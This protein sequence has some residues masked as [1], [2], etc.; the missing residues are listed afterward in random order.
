MPPK[1]RTVSRVC[2]TFENLQILDVTVCRAIKVSNIA[3]LCIDAMGRLK[4]VTAVPVTPTASSTAPSAA[5]RGARGDGLNADV[6]TSSRFDFKE[7][8]LVTKTSGAK[9]ILVIS[10]VVGIVAVLAALTVAGCARVSLPRALHWRSSKVHFPGP[11]EPPQAFRPLKALGSLLG[12]RRAEPAAALSAAVNTIR[13][14]TDSTI[15]SA[16][17]AMKHPPHRIT[18]F[19]AAVAKE[20][21]TLQRALTSLGCSTAQTFVRT[22]DAVTNAAL[23]TAHGAAAGINSTLTLGGA[24]LDS[25]L[26]GFRPKGMAD[27]LHALHTSSYPYSHAIADAVLH[28]PN[29]AGQGPSSCAGRELGCV[30]AHIKATP[31][32][33][34]AERDALGHTLMHHILLHKYRTQ[35]AVAAA[36]AAGAEEREA[37]A[38]EE[39]EEGV[40]YDME[41]DGR[42][43]GGGKGTGARAG[44]TGS[45]EGSH[46]AE[47]VT[48]HD[49]LV[50]ALIRRAGPALANAPDVLGNTPLHLLAR[51]NDAP[52]LR[53][54]LRF[55]EVDCNA[56]TVGGATPLHVA[57]RWGQDAAAVALLGCTREA[58]SSVPLLTV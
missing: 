28:A 35:A 30:R 53:K 40:I 18:N 56:R 13:T 42:R 32:A 51:H 16:R 29:S 20:G 49:D 52:L 48:S 12:R 26:R 5:L 44:V 8:L 43:G 47:Y 46:G 39:R 23:T 34:L 21:T 25:L 22:R 15:N 24:A 10:L 58:G 31:R 14:S 19:P 2:T 57:L 17:S 45:L 7:T 54:I 6:G 1:F 33:A 38:A 41:G 36:T 55:S 27:I 4:V 9:V 37:E 3:V 11:L 50:L